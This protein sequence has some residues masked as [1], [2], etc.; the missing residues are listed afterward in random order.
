MLNEFLE[1]HY[2][3]ELTIDAAVKLAVRALLEVVEHGAKNIDVGILE[4]KKTLSKLQETDIEKIVE[5]I[6]KEEELEDGNKDKEKEK[7]KEKDKD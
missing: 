5:E 1:K 2:T 6:K 7:G 4:R 3:D